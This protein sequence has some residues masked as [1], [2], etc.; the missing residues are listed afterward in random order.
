MVMDLFLL[1]LDLEIFSSPISSSSAE[2]A[3]K[4]R[5]PI[6][7]W[8]DALT[9]VAYE[10]IYNILTCSSNHRGMVNCTYDSKFNGVVELLERSRPAGV[11]TSRARVIGR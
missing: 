6:T 11:R 2:N 1:A 7:T 4:H 8:M 5:N 9:Y 10:L 3:G